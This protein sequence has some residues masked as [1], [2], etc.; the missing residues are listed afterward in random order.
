LIEDWD[1]HF[2]PF[3]PSGEVSLKYLTAP[4]KVSPTS[5]ASIEKYLNGLAEKIMARAAAT[6][7]SPQVQE[8]NITSAAHV[9]PPVQPTSEPPRGLNRGGQ[10]VPKICK[11]CLKNRAGTGHG[12]FGCPFP[13]SEN[14]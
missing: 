11:N 4:A 12:R 6:H 14:P 9:S 5:P 13:K 2:K 3:L 7:V 8:A 1:A 10:G